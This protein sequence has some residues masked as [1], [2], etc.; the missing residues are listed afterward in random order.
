[1]YGS[2]VT[3][4]SPRASPAEK[5][6]ETV[7]RLTRGMMRLAREHAR[8]VGLSLPQLFLLRGLREEGRIPVSRWVD[9]M[10]VSPSA[11][12]SLLDG[13]EE[14]GYVQRTHDAKDRRQVLVSL[15]PKG[16]RLSEQVQAEFRRKWR[17]L[18]DEIP[19]GELEVAAATLERIGAR[20]N[21]AE[22][23]VESLAVATPGRRKSR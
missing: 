5:L 9:I 2:T 7:S 1:M 10:G 22:G 15:T 8:D 3:L 20:L 12:T 23:G 14:Q 16:R 21:P 13:L 18:C 17:S 6:S 11:A 4:A 19:A